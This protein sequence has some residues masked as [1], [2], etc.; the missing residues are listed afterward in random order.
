M[1]PRRMSSTRLTTLLG[2]TLRRQRE[3]RGL[4]Q[5]QLAVRARVSQAA[6]ARIEQGDRGP[7]A[8][9]LERL[10][11]ALGLQLAV[12]VEPLDAH[13]DARIAALSGESILDRI[14]ATELH[15]V[16]E[17]LADLPYVLT[18]CTAALVQGAPVPSSAV[19]IALRWSDADRFTAWLTRTY[20]QRWHAQWEVFGYLP[21]DP[22]EPYEHRWQTVAGE[23]RATMCDDLP[24]AIEV[25]HGERS[26]PVV[27]LAEIEVTDEAT[28][29]LLRRYRQL[30]AAELQA[31]APETEPSGRRG[32]VPVDG[33]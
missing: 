31:A 15:V 23:I 26:Y 1:H 16:M 5:R 10:F 20:A 21:V 9:T 32:Q 17:K 33:G 14:A 28:S 12:S 27:P 2:A 22:R 13:L 19:E 8:E 24:E 3:T 6:V 4:T 29:D 18:G 7:R 11:A 25:R 30:R